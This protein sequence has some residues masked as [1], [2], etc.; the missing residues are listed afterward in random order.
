MGL[1]QD[2]PRKPLGSL[3]PPEPCSGTGPENAGGV[4]G[5]DF[6]QRVCQWNCRAGAVTPPRM[7][8]HEGD[9]RGL[10]KRAGPA[11]NQHN[12]HSGAS[13]ARPDRT[14]SPRWVPPATTEK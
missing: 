11:V 5:L 13:A 9:A 12:R 14:E 6:L 4:I 10:R 2:L 8:D 7:L 3:R 1:F